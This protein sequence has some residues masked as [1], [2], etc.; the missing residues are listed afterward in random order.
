MILVYS[1][2]THHETGIPVG[3]LDRRELATP[4][5]AGGCTDEMVVNLKV[6][7]VTGKSTV[8]VDGGFP[9]PHPGCVVY[10]RVRG[11]HL[12]QFTVWVTCIAGCIRDQQ[13]LRNTRQLATEAP[14]DGISPKVRNQ[15]NGGVIDSRIPGAVLRNSGGRMSKY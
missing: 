3:V 11:K 12:V 13:V 8:G 9:E 2:G 14:G 7:I 5:T 1:T 6:S 15:F 10:G 4:G